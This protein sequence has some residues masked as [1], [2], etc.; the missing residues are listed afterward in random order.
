MRGCGV[1][2]STKSSV[3][4]FILRSND[5]VVVLSSVSA[6]AYNRCVIIFKFRLIKVSIRRFSSLKNYKNVSVP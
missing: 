6:F 3:G 2:L 4:T 5:F 1:V